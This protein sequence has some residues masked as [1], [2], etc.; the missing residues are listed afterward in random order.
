MAA[1]PHKFPCASCGSNMEWDPG[2]AR[3]R[4]PRC[5]ATQE[6]QAQGSLEEIPFGDYA[7]QERRIT[8]TAVEV[9]CAN[10]GAVTQFEASE[11]AGKCPFCAT[12]VVMQPKA[13]DPLIA[14]HGVLPF[15][16]TPQ[17]ATDAVK[18][19]IGGLWFAP[20]DLKRVAQQDG[21]QGIYIPYWTFDAETYSVYAGQRGEWYTDQRGQRQIA[22]Q[23]RGGA[24]ACAFDDMLTPATTAVR[25]AHLESLE[26]WDLGH[27]RP[28]EPAYLSGFKAQRY[29]IQLK[30]GFDYAAAKMRPPIESLVRRDIGGDSQK[31][32]DLRT[33]YDK[34]TFKHVLLPVWIGA[35]RYKGKVFQVV[36]NAQQASVG[37]ER[38][39]SAVKVAILILFILIGFWL[40]F[41]AQQ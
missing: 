38:P 7:T 9:K 20:N 26:P 29:Q 6:I 24:V 35:Y 19:W 3:L 22:W 15:A 10:C 13:A 40:W 25:A 17:R 11:A 14:P 16:V 30:Q 4:C 18:A 36:V 21:L 1:T 2:L 5:A 37:G 12:P 34:V 23:E 31:I 33:Q 32:H 27:I 41:G 28:Y 39:V 8:E